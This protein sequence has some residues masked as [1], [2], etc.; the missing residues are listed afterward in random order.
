MTIFSTCMSSLKWYW[1]HTIKHL[2]HFCHFCLKGKVIKGRTNDVKGLKYDCI[3]QDMISRNVK[4]VHF[5]DIT[6]NMHWYSPSTTVFPHWFCPS[7]GHFLPNSLSC[8]SPLPKNISHESSCW[9]NLSTSVLQWGYRVHLLS[10]LAY[11]ETV[12]VCGGGGDGGGGQFVS[13]F[14]WACLKFNPW[15]PEGQFLIW[16]WGISLWSP[17]LR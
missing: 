10:D 5:V 6:L 1:E 3:L 7:L 4:C 11:S 15:K 14:R 9:K 17:F 8:T 2:L 12:D 16:R 13:Q